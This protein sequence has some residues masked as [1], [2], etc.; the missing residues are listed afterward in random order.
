MCKKPT[1]KSRRRLI[2]R[3]RRHSCLFVLLF[4]L[5]KRRE[6][7]AEWEQRGRD[8]IETPNLSCLEIWKS[9]QEKSKKKID[10]ISR[11]D[12]LKIVPYHGKINTEVT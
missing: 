8:G 12:E 4:P 1:V 6:E 10:A 7:E 5:E 11:R 2:K 3:A 9:N